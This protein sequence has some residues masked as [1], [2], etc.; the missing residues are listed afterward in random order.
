MVQLNVAVAGD[1][2]CLNVEPELNDISIR[3]HVLFAFHA[4][5]AFGLRFRN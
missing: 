1:K 2:K 3:H 4:Y 5:F